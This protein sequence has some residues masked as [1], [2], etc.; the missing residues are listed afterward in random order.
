MVFSF[1]SCN[2]TGIGLDQAAKGKLETLISLQIQQVLDKIEEEGQSEEEGIASPEEK[3]T[4]LLNW[5]E[6]WFHALS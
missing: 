4:D 3:K 6:E 5:A 1:L 2:T